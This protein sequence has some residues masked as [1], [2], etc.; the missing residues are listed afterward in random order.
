[1]NAGLFNTIFRHICDS[2]CIGW[3]LCKFHFDQHPGFLRL[4]RNVVFVGALVGASPEFCTVLTPSEIRG[5]PPR[6]AR[7]GANTTPSLIEHPDTQRLHI[8]HLMAIAGAGPH[9]PRLTNNL[10]I[11]SGVIATSGASWYQ[12]TDKVVHGQ[13]R[14]EPWAPMAA[15]DRA[16]IRSLAY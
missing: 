5:N 6:A 4:T 13:S 2:K 8:G 12:T 7:A 9:L 14:A 16:D 11:D 3:R 15:T 1:M 10:V